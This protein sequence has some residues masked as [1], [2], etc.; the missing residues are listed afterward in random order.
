M[1]SKHFNDVKG[2]EFVLTQKEGNSYIISS[3]QNIGPIGKMPGSITINVG[4]N[5]DNGEITYN[6][7]IEAFTTMNF[8]HKL[9]LTLHVKNISGNINDKTLH[10]VLE[11]YAGWETIPLFLSSV[12]FEGKLVK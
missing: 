10:F 11:N 1:N 4:V 2:V 5:I 7:E 8:L 3:K 6:K 12:T 9:P